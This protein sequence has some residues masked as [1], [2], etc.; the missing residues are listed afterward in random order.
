[1]PISLMSTD[2]RILNKA[3]AK[4]IQQHI[5]R[6]IPILIR[7][8]RTHKK[9]RILSSKHGVGKSRYLHTKEQSWTVILHSM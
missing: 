1:M 3:L 8:P 5:T 6:I 7:A 9:K 2:A 4:Q